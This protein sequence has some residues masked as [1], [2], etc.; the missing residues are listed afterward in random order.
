M[1]AA[2]TR[3]LL[4]VGE[5]S[6]PDDV[7]AVTLLGKCLGWPIVADVLSGLRLHSNGNWAIREVRSSIVS[8]IDHILLLGQ[9]YWP[10]VKPDVIVQVGS[11]LTSKRLCQFLVSKLLRDKFGVSKV[12]TRV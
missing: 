7:L 4:V 5:L 2:A 9:D 1:I 8:Y 6:N 3:G 10:T 11:H 12:L